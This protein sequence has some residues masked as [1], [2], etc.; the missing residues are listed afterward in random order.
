MA[1]SSSF[2]D[3]TN[4][5]NV[6]EGR[7]SDSIELA[8]LINESAEGAIDYLFSDLNKLESAT[9]EM[10]GLL[11]QEVYYS[12][13]NA[14]IAER[15]GKVIGAALCF[16]ADGLIINSQMESHYTN[17]KL[18]Y[19]RYFVDNKL[20]GCWHLDALCV[21]AEHRND[22]VGGELLSAVKQKA[23]QYNFASIGVFVFGSNTAAIRFYQRHGFV[24]RKIIDT[25]GHEFLGTR[26][27]LNL[28]EYMFL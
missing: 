9:S 5:L 3:Q 14:V 20:D 16:S 1:T 6:R 19:I 7:V 27:S 11:Q 12:Y 4:R 24:V 15:A 13:A 2:S 25:T 8:E 23:R 26:K 28:M 18:R 22:G 21:R 17:E 10:S